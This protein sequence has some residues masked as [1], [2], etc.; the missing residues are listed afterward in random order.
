MDTLH[1][2]FGL[3]RPYSSHYNAHSVL[4]VNGTE[5]YPGRCD[6]GKLHRVGEFLLPLLGSPPCKDTN[7]QTTPQKR[8]LTRSQPSSHTSS[9]QN[10]EKYVSIVNKAPSLWYICYNS[11]NRLRQQVNIS[12][13]ASL[14]SSKLW[15]TCLRILGYRERLMICPRLLTWLL[16]P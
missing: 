11:L 1:S 6:Q 15:S 4:R 16:V 3:Q 12:N 7:Q 10:C 9:L 13:L 8:A 5:E 14:A 2:S